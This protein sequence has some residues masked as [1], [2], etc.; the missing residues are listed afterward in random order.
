MWMAEI[1]GLQIFKDLSEFDYM[2]IVRVAPI[3]F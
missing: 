3:F 2:G 1:I